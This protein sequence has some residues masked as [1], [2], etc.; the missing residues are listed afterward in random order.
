MNL[1]DL[2]P[3]LS[4]WF[5]PPVTPGQRLLARHVE[6]RQEQI[7]ERLDRLERMHAE[8]A[9]PRHEWRTREGDS[10]DVG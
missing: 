10:G 3:V 2:F 9:L 1:R 7:R 4:R 5:P 6:E 8:G